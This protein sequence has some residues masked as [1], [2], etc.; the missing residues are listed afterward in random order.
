MRGPGD[1]FVMKCKCIIITSEPPIG[2]VPIIPD[3][4]TAQFYMTHVSR[5]HS[6]VRLTRTNKPT[7]HWCYGT[8][9]KQRESYTV[10]GGQKLTGGRTHAE[11]RMECGI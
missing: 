1:R 6:D 5:V 11:A 8:S 2:S 9:L 4:T 3:A 10:I 7:M